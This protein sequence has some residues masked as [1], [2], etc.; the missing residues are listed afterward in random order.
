M[1]ES[2][3]ND[4]SAT[5]VEPSDWYTDPDINVLYSEPEFDEK[6][7]AHLVRAWIVRQGRSWPMA[8]DALA[9][10]E[11]SRLVYVP[12][13]LLSA[14]VSFSWSGTAVETRTRTGS[15][16]E[17]RSRSLGTDA[18]GI[19]RFE[20]YTVEVPTSET[21]T[22]RHPVSGVVSEIPVDLDACDTGI[23][24]PQCGLPD[25]AKAAEN[26]TRISEFDGDHFFLLRPECRTTQEVE[27]ALYDHMVARLDSQGPSIVN[28]SDLVEFKATDVDVLTK[29]AWVHLYPIIVSSYKHRNREYSVQIDGHT[30]HVHVD[31][32]WTVGLNKRLRRLATVAGFLI[33]CVAGAWWTST[34]DGGTRGGG[35]PATPIVSETSANAGPQTQQG[36]ETLALDRPTR[37][38]IQSGLSIAGFDPGPADGQFGPGTRR[39][40]RAW[41]SSLGRPASGYLFLSEAEELENLGTSDGTSAEDGVDSEP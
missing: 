27:G 21:Y 12:Y 30:R 22:V 1:A 24:S 29:T 36:E 8:L 34:R 25:L 31:V 17:T 15:R 6:E 33:V 41:Q 28:R 2:S 18:Q 14:K 38:R 37:R 10:T 3:A 39:A 13:L 7:A 5:Y 40:I 19:P 23:Y 20:S 32:P 26:A 9:L 4:E 11:M 16:R 35:L